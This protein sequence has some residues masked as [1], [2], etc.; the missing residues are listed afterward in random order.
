MPYVLL[1]LLAPVLLLVILGNGYGVPV[2]LPPVG[3]AVRKI[4]ATVGLG[5]GDPAGTALDSLPVS[6]SLGT[7]LDSLPFDE[8]PGVGLAVGFTSGALVD[9]SNVGI[10]AVEAV[11]DVPVGP[12]VAVPTGDSVGP[13]VGVFIVFCADVPVGGKITGLVVEPAAKVPA[14]P[15]V[16]AGTGDKV[17]ILVVEPAAKVPAGP[18]VW[19][20]TGDKV[21]ILAVEG[22]AKVP[23]GPFVWAATGAIVGLVIG[24]LVVTCWGGPV[25]GTVIE[26]GVLVTEGATFG[27]AVAF[28]VVL[29]TDPQHPKYCPVS[30][31]QQFPNNPEHALNAWQLAAFKVV[32]GAVMWGI[33]Q[34]TSAKLYV[35]LSLQLNSNPTNCGFNVKLAYIN[36]QFGS[37]VLLGSWSSRHESSIAVNQ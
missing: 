3:D 19:A 2:V 6:E 23:A 34:S 17:G 31:G 8:S 27:A 4:T 9:G 24:D 5:A 30:V 29:G 25:V 35:T 33:D 12:F 26:L 10:L 16:W 7:A 36:P 28:P 13:V 22:A 18:F 32:G 11:G 37:M 20:A 21:G 1:P 14:G 15:F